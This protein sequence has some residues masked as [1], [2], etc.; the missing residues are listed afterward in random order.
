VVGFPSSLL[1]PSHL[2]V[3]HLIFVML[4]DYIECGF[5]L[6]LAF[7]RRDDDV[8]PSNIEHTLN[9]GA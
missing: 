3:F 2:R 9:L 5:R 1:L 4:G 7:F 6:H 8:C